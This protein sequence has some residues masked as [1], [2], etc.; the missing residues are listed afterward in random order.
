MAANN[1]LANGESR[2]NAGGVTNNISF[3]NQS[4]IVGENAGQNIVDPSA[5]LRNF[6]NTFVGYKAGQFSINVFKNIF[7][8][9]EAGMN[10]TAGSEN[11][12]IGRNKDDGDSLRLN[13]IISLG[14]DNTTP[15]K[16]ISIGTSNNIIGFANIGMGINNSILGL[17]NISF[18]NGNTILT[19]NDTLVIGNNNETYADN[20]GSIIVGNNIIVPNT[21]SASNSIYIGHNLDCSNYVMNIG[22]VVYLYD[23][24][25]NNEILFLGHKNKYNSN[26]ALHTAVGFNDTDIFDID[27]HMQ[28]DAK[29]VASNMWYSFYVKDGIYTDSISLGNYTSNINYSITLKSNTSIASN[30]H[31][32][33]PLLPDTSNVVLSVDENCVMYWKP[34]RF[35]NA[36]E[37]TDQL[38][39]G[40]KNK[41]YKDDE[42]SFKINTYINQLF[43]SLFKQNLALVNLDQIKNGTS[44]KYIQDGFY[45]QDM[46]VAGGITTNKI[47]VLGN[48]IQPNTNINNYIAN[49]I[50]NT[51]NELVN[52]ITILL[53]RI[54]FL[55][56]RVL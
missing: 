56:S 3:E 42:V 36:I 8:G 51:S 47:Q 6:Y 11:I 41:Y 53:Q 19:S 34:A 43:P 44:N 37:T 54:Q 1:I 49:T 40:K 46:T 32:T 2:F 5:T 48:D 13:N 45:D 17:Q 23:N 24:F 21:P 22:N 20:G 10:V 35:D 27:H 16:S 25:S 14:F 39:E 55:E 38:T 7:V 29:N 52:M 18:G 33:L 12:I 26:H 15:D 28:S 9:F 50:G 30:I 31:Y 4:T